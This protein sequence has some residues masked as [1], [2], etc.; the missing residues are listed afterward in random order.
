MNPP[1]HV[2]VGQVK[3]RVKWSRKA[4]KANETKGLIGLSD[5]NRALILLH[6]DS[7]PDVR[8]LTLLHEVMHALNTTCMA[9]PRWSKQNTE[10]RVIR[11]WEHAFLQF[12]A[13]NPSTVAYWGVRGAWRSKKR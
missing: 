13:D 8:R 10:E 4:W 9:D 7:S 5:H 2:Q 1:R 3:Y 12:V 11:Q 6:P